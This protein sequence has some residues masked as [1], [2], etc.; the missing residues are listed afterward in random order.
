MVNENLPPQSMNEVLHPGHTGDSE[1]PHAGEDWNQQQAKNT[2]TELDIELTGDHWQVIR[3]LQE[4]YARH[5]SQGINK[6]ELHDA[7]DEKFHPQGGMK[8]LYKILPGGPVTQGCRL[9]GLKPPAGVTDK[10]FGSVV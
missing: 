8:F 6:R 9:A 2:A 5:D 1:F 3:A 10:G 4:Y 7:L